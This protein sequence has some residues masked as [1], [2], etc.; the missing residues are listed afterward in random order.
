MTAMARPLRIAIEDG[1]YHV[2]NRGIERR[3][4]FR[5]SADS[6]HFLQLLAQLP[7]RFGLLIHCYA[8][9]PNHYHLL[10]QTP[11]ANLSQAIQWLNVSYSVW[12][13]RKHRRAGPLFQGR[14]K[15]VLVATD[16]H[17]REVS[18]YIH[19]NPIRTQRF[20]LGK[21]ERVSNPAN[22]SRLL[23]QQRIE[24]LRSYAL[25]SYPV[26]I[27]TQP[28]SAW[29]TTQILMSDFAG[30]TQGQ[31]RRAYQRYVEEPIRTGALD[32]ILDQVLERAVQGSREF[33]A[34]M[35]ELAKG[36][37][38][39]RQAVQQRATRLDW[40]AL[41]Q[42]LAQLKGE[43]WEAFAERRGDDGRDL[44][45]LLA[46]RSGGYTLTELGTLVGVSYAAVAQAVSKAEHR[47]AHSVATRKLYNQLC[48][49]FKIKT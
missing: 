24:F 26:Y 35:L 10:V 34:K 1:W 45:L 4:L 15:S 31:W 19:L 20:G 30:T 12:F 18:R 14:F 40:A 5:S 21:E 49:T 33:R 42:V 43:S 37:P 23:E 17:H 16:G 9:M 41:Q 28:R 32:S 22:H 36:E 44:A 13:N 2:I 27:G 29:L 25:S 7:T 3:L 8:L 11:Q 6:H 39:H 38:A 47:I 48:T 46:R